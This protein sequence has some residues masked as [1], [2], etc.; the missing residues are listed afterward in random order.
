MR[1]A[2][3]VLIVALW[4]GPATAQPAP[5]DYTPL[6]TALAAYTVT[7]AIDRAVAVDCAARGTCHEVGLLRGLSGQPAAFAAVGASLDLAVGW[8]L[9]R[10]GHGARAQRHAAFWTAVGL[11]VA[12]GCIIA[13]NLHHGGRL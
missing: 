6:R 1:L 3:A 12:K 2:L 13:R 5:V 7:S 9:L 8:A 10:L 11:T 4:A